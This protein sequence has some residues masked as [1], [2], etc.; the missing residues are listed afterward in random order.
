MLTRDMLSVTSPLSQ[1]LWSM[2]EEFHLMR[3]TGEWNDLPLDMKTKFYDVE[4]ALLDLFEAAR[5]PSRRELE[6]TK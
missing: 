6:T 1:R 5:K 2:A 3:L 4:M